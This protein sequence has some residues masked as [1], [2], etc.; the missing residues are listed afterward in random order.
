MSQAPEATLKPNQPFTIDDGQPLV[1]RNVPVVTYEL[2]QKVA[3]VPPVN[4]LSAIAQGILSLM[5]DLGLAVLPRQANGPHHGQ[6]LLQ[7]G[8]PRAQVDAINQPTGL[9]PGYANYQNNKP[10]WLKEESEKQEKNKH[11]PGKT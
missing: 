10:E 1:A 2:V 11:R 7:P 3:P 9:L 5:P 8:L 6:Q 4:W